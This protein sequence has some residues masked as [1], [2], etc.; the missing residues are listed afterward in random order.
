MA[1]AFKPLDELTLMDDYMFG[2]V[3]QDPALF[4]PLLEY[5]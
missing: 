2:V 5:I 4:K 1:A 3:M